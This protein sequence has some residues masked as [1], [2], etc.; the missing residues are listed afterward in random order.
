MLPKPR[1][2]GA[3][4]SGTKV[5]QV[6]TRYSQ[7]DYIYDNEQKYIF[8]L[9]PIGNV[10]VPREI[11]NEKCLQNYYSRNKLQM[12]RIAAPSTIPC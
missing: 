10:F 5:Q 1:F 11:Q 4:K 9:K 7:L 6:M 2:L 3:S 8:V 12:K